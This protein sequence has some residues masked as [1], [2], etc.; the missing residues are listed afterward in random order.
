MTNRAVSRVRSRTAPTQ[1]MLESAW[2]EQDGVGRTAAIRPTVDAPIRGSRYMDNSARRDAAEFPSNRPRGSRAPRC[3][4]WPSQLLTAIL[5]LMSFAYQGRA[6]EGPCEAAD[7]GMRAD[8]SDNT[9]ALS[10]TLAECAGRTIHIAQGTYTLSPQGFA[11]G[12][13]IPSGTTLVGDG[14]QGPHPTV[15]RV[16]ASGTFQGVLWVRNESHVAIRGIRL[17]G[18]T[19]GSGCERRLDYGHAIYIESDPGASAAV[20]GVEI[21]D[22]TFHNFNG[23]SWVTL[24]AGERSPGINKVTIGNNAFESD[25]SLTGSCAAMSMVY[26]AAMISIHGANLSAEGMVKNVAVTS[27]TMNAGYVKEGVAIWSGTNSITVKSNVIA[28]TGLHLPR[29]PGAELGRY[30]VSVYNSAYDH[31][32]LH[33]DTV[34]IV[35]NTISNPVSCGVYVASG[36]N[37]Q[38]SG[39]RISGQIDRNNG[40]LLKGAIALNHADN[41]FSLDGNELTN[42]YIGISSIGSTVKMGANKIVAA[43]G[44]MATKF[45]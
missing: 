26:T 19:Y 37:L 28:D 39:N 34:W 7:H 29:P 1:Q 24:N 33:P 3:R 41:V 21:S 16:A 35:D 8:G 25:A 15:L 44:G 27:N 36:Q 11:V 42:N 4:Q 5:L 10:R 23:L 32:G 6:A 38:I 30:A 14:S 31:G 20:E 45:Y 40:T 13:K 17:E 12:S 43:P 22:D 2:Q 9:E 18:S